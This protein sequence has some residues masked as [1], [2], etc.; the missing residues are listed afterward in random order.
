MTSYRAAHI[1]RGQNGGDSH[2]QAAQAAGGST[3]RFIAKFEGAPT[4]E[5][6]TEAFSRRAGFRQKAGALRN[7]RG[8]LYI[9]GAFIEREFLALE[10]PF[11]IGFMLVEVGLFFGVTA[12]G[13][14][15][16]KNG[17]LNSIAGAH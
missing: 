2:E 10:K 6:Q 17:A 4:T 3:K 11:D 1:E 14:L 7:E 9:A 16:A 12:K 5:T 13:L 15:L 8:K